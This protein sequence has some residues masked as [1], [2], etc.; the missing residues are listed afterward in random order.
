MKIK[1]DRIVLRRPRRRRL[2]RAARK[3]RD[4]AL[5]V[6]YMIVL[7]T[8]RGKSQRDIATML[9][10]SIA[11]VKRTRTRWRRDGEAGLIDRREDNGASVKADDAWAA[12]LLVVLRDTPRR[13]GQ[14]RPTWTLELMITVMTDRGHTRVSRTTLSRLLGRLGVRRGMARPTAGCPWPKRAKNKR[15]AL[16]RRLIATLPEGQAACGRT[17]SMC[18]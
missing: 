7:H 16:I 1:D 3:A 10:T 15:L 9:G 12:D 14:R 6:R 4:A 18:T 2:Q 8:A 5:R 11:T 17:R 13:H